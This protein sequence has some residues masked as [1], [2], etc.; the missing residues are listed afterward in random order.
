LYFNG[1]LETTEPA[2]STSWNHGLGKLRIGDIYNGMGVPG[3]F[4]GQIP[5][6]KIY[7]RALTADEVKRNFNGIRSRFNI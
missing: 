1:N 6:V 2:A 3:E 5:I 7:N 4:N